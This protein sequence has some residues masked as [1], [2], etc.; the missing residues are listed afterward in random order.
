MARAL[1]AIG[2]ALDLPPGEAVAFLA[3]VGERSIAIAAAVL[4]SQNSAHM[5]IGTSAAAEVLGS[6]MIAPWAAALE[7]FPLAPM[8]D[9]APAC[10]PCDLGDHSRCRGVG[11]GCQ[12]AGGA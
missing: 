12:H 3:L 10:K 2:A 8:E 5:A 7:H 4:R 1:R 6:E 11:C 9:D